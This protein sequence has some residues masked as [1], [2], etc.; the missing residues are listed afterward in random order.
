MDM[1]AHGGPAFCW[2]QVVIFSVEMIIK[3]RV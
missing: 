2:R 1:F 3:E